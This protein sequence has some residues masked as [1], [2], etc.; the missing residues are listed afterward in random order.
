MAEYNIL[1]M[2][3]KI[4]YTGLFD[5]G[6]L[7]KLLDLW[8]KERG[9]DKRETRNFEEV[10]EDSRQVTIWMFPYK[11]VSDSV[12]FEIKLEMVF[13][14]LVETEVE[15]EGKKVKLMKGTADIRM[16]AYM[17]TDYEHK[18]DKTPLYFFMRIIFDRYV[19]RNYHS[20]AKNEFLG[21]FAKLEEEIKSYLN[22]FRY[23]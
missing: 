3:R 2:D 9:Y 19:Y 6:G 10:Y 23:R 11:K 7:V 16:D 21:D 22:M 17:I 4:E 18:W 14:K 1:V 8:F 5:L 12:K 20:R 15:K 13:K